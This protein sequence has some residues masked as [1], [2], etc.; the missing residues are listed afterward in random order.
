MSPKFDFRLGIWTSL[1]L[2]TFLL[3]YSLFQLFLQFTHKVVMRAELRVRILPRFL[4]TLSFRPFLNHFLYCFDLFFDN[5]IKNFVFLVSLVVP[6]DIRISRL[7]WVWNTVRSLL[8]ESIISL[9]ISV[10]IVFLITVYTIVIGLSSFTKSAYFAHELLEIEIFSKTTLHTFLLN[11]TWYVIGLFVGT[12]TD[13]K[14]IIIQNH[15]F[16]IT[17]LWS[18]DLFRH[19]WILLSVC[20]C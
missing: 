19:I 4:T 20:S 11:Y 3:F 16:A 7:P 1:F 14:R 2:F 17:A 18:W 13:D 8:I 5:L 10:I 6:Q 12:P 9:H 15:L